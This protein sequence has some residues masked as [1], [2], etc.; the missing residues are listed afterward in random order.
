[1]D[2]PSEGGTF[3]QRGNDISFVVHGADQDT[4]FSGVILTG[5]IRVTYSVIQGEFVLGYKLR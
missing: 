4:R 2:S 1:V 3:E 5:I